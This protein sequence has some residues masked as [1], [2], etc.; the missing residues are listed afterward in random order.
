MWAIME[1]EIHAGG[2]DVIDACEDRKPQ[3]YEK[4][5]EL[6]KFFGLNI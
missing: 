1:S 6:E 5:I 4:D 3:E 2:N